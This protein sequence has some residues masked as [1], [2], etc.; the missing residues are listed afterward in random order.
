MKG[1]DISERLLDLSVR[2]IKLVKTLANN[3][4]NKHIGNQL[5][6]SATSA[7]ANYEEERSS[8]SNADFVHKLKLVLKELRESIYWLKVIRKGLRANQIQF[9]NKN[10][11]L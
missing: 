1:D 3:F 7:G 5:L 2:T 11:N 8:E 4:I 6:R 10:V 9:L